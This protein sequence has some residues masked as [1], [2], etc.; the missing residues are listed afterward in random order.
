MDIEKSLRD[1]GLTKYEAAA[2][3]NISRRGAAEASTIYKEAK[4]PFGKIYETL[5]TSHFPQVNPKSES[6]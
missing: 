5:G 4:I 6:F 1:L 3:L 2:Y